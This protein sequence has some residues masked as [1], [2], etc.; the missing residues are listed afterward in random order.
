MSRISRGVGPSV[1]PAQHAPRTQPEYLL[2][3]DVGL[4]RPAKEFLPKEGDGLL[5]GI[6]APIGGRPRGFENTILT[7]QLQ[8]AGGVMAVDSRIERQDSADG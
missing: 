3:F 2:N 4:R 5:S 7:H 6:Y 8:H 1:F